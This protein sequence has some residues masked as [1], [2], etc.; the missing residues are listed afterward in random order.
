MRT[1][2]Y[3][4]E[5]ILVLETAI[6]DMNPEFY[7]YLIEKLLAEGALDAYLQPII[8]KKGRPGVMLTVLARKENRDVIMTEIF[9]ETSTL[10]VRVRA[11]NRA[12]LPRGFLTVTTEYG[13][14][15]VKIAY[16]GNGETPARFS[17]EFEDC[18][19]RALERGVPIREVYNAALLAAEKTK[20][21]ENGSDIQ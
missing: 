5:E 7:P 2:N 12:C 20:E 14:V 21:K 17:P 16:A 8:M 11:E 4:W 1:M 9:K 3:T 6:D 10:G 19:A 18:R 13:P 15:R